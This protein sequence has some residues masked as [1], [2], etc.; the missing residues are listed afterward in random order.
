MTTQKQIID[1]S[2]SI[3]SPSNQVL[4][5][6]VVNNNV[7]VET[8]Q[9]KK[10]GLNLRNKLLLTILPT[11]LIPLGIAS[12]IGI[13]FVKNEAALQQQEELENGIIIASSVTQ[14]FLEKGAQLNQLLARNNFIIRELQVDTQKAEV[15]GLT[16]KSIPELEKQFSRTKLLNPDTDIN[17]YLKIIAE[18]NQLAEIILTES[19]GF[20]VGY[21]SRTSDF[22]QSDEQWWQIGAEEGKSILEPK[23]DESTQ[24]VILELVNSIKNPD[25]GKLL[26]VTKIGVSVDSLK[27][28]IREE[29]VGFKESQQLQIID[30]Q[31]AKVLS[32][33]NTEEQTQTNNEIQIEEIV[34]GET[35][36][37]AAKIL[38][39]NV[40]ALSTNNSESSVTIPEEI[41]TEIEQ[42]ISALE[43]VSQVEF[44]ADDKETLDQA[45]QIRNILHFEYNDKFFELKVVPNTTLVISSSI[46][47]AQAATAGNNLARIL[48]ISGVILGLIAIGVIFWLAQNL[49]QPLAKLSSKVEQAGTGDLD[50]QADLEGTSETIVLG[51]NFNKLVTQLKGSIDEQKLIAQTQKD[52]KEQLELGIYQLLEEIQDAADGDL[53][54]RASLDSMEMSTVADLFNAVID[55]LQDIAIQV[56]DSSKQV[57]T[58]LNENEVSIQML[59]NQAIEEAQDTRDTLEEIEKMGISIE[60]VA[61]N[62]NEAANLVNSA[63]QETQEGTNVMDETVNSILNLRTTVGE[64]AKKMKRLGESSQKISQVVSLIEE[65]ALKTNLLAINAS[66]EASRA[67][68]QGQGF[69]VVAEQVGALAS[70]SATATKEIAKIVAAIQ[71][72]TKEVS[73]AMELGTTQVVDST[74]LVESTKQRLVQ[75]LE[76]YGSIN[77]LMKQISQST[78]SQTDTSQLVTNLM[79]LIAEKSE[80]RLQ[81][82]VAIA[83]S[84][85]STNQVAQKLE[86]A[87]EQFE[88]EKQ[89]TSN[90]A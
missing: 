67:G 25:T 71:A 58:S 13:T 2:S 24:Q 33:V 76:R 11:V 44:E 10:R 4:T 53:T 87:V 6:K 26:G 50:V 19:N 1:S 57:T 8:K 29:I 72:E 40:N 83:K 64:T 12:A 89:L 68:E 75:V 41:I 16:R 18:S 28:N 61:N 42:N 32:T 77:E 47:V 74:H 17:S 20:N 30:S 37:Q 82:S 14:R 63:Y 7:V 22:V 59:A 81:D 36:G 66:V 45:S 88:V 56:K 51:D 60:Q 85:Q 84:I 69:T 5:P 46:D 35:I 3:S 73:Q 65:I 27:Q 52:E 80:Q 31:T 62:A 43:G 21:S 49:S 34:G 79:Q 39:Q 38:S 90:N 48:Q 15:E 78:V 86:S 55:S 9:V 54:V 70:Q 23:I